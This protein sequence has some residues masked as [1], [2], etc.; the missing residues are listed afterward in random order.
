MYLLQHFNI[1]VEKLGIFWELKD[2]SISLFKK[3]QRMQKTQSVP[4][5]SNSQSLMSRIEELVFTQC[6]PKVRAKLYT[7]LF[8]KCNSVFCS[9]LGD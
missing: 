6:V 4:V 7:K 1:D 9:I 3:F 5:E 2:K 8:G